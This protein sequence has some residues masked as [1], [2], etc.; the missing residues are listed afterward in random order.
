MRKKKTLA[1]AVIC[2]LSMLLI[3]GSFSG[4]GSAQV[5]TTG[6]ISGI[7]RDQQGAVINNADVTVRNNETGAEY[8]AKSS[9]EGTFFIS[10]LPV[11]TYTVTVTA[12]GFKQTK[13]TE[14][15]IEVGKSATVEVKLEV[16]AANESVTVTGGAEVLPIRRFPAGAAGDGSADRAGKRED[17]RKY[18]ENPARSSAR[19]LW[20]TQVS[21]TPTP[22]VLACE[23]GRVG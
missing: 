4:L 12:Q 19:V 9:E 8:T 5:T 23:I 13:V 15:K 22:S 20:L 11:S 6:R 16:G 17:G 10:A 2:T 14:I 18:A 3:L 1:R 7:V 21:A